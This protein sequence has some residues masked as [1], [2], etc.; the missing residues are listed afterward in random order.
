MINF[1]F[2]LAAEITTMTETLAQKIGCLRL[3]DSKYGG[4]AKGNLFY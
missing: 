3:V 1:L 4:S 2:P